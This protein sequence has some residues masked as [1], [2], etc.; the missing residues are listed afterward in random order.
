MY[1]SEKFSRKPHLENNCVFFTQLKSFFGILVLKFF[2]EV[3]TGF[4]YHRVSKFWQTFYF[5]PRCPCYFHFC[6]GIFTAG[7]GRVDRLNR[8]WWSGGCSPAHFMYKG[9]RK[10]ETVV[11]RLRFQQHLPA[12]CRSLKQNDHCLGTLYLLLQRTRR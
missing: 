12:I 5:C 10:S 6:T 9:V 2:Q 3:L 11:Q 7:V 4:P 1:Q 8:V